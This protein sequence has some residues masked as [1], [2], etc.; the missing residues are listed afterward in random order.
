MKANEAL[1]ELTNM[2]RYF[3]YVNFAI[4]S[5]CAQSVAE[6]VCKRNKQRSWIYMIANEAKSVR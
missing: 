2:K 1:A 6:T 5:V 3:C 4:C